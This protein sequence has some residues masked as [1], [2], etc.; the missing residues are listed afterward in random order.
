MD[1]SYNVHSIIITINSFKSVYIGFA[2]IFMV[3]FHLLFI[4]VDCLTFTTCVIQLVV[5]LHYLVSFLCH[6]LIFNALRVFPDHFFIY[7]HEYWLA[8][9]YKMLSR[10]VWDWSI[11]FSDLF[12]VLVFSNPS[13]HMFRI[14]YL[15]QELIMSGHCYTRL[16]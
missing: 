3:S 1:L 9:W 10:F 8:L 7:N 14:Y 16:W 11:Y 4:L 6:L 13:V 2:C 12:Y 15:L 5:T